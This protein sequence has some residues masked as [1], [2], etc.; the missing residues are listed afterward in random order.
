MSFLRVVAA[1]TADSIEEEAQKQGQPPNIVHSLMV[2]SV[3]M[4]EYDSDPIL[5][6][7][8]RG[9]AVVLRSGNEPLKT[10]VTKMAE[11]RE[12]P[13]LVERL[14]KIAEEKLQSGRLH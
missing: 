3:L 11:V 1:N 5:Q 10:F 7:L 12:G 4:G 13:H 14:I 9:V 6:G 2:Q 8:I